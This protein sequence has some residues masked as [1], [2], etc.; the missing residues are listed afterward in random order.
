VIVRARSLSL[1]AN[2]WEHLPEPEML[3]PVT[4]HTPRKPRVLVI[5]FGKSNEFIVNIPGHVA[6]A[7]L[8]D[9]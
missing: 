7:R 8:I 1:G 4:T 5:S 6:C 2:M 3:A 9:N